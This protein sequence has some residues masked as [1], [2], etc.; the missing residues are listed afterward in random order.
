M[1]LKLTATLKL[2][3]K[4]LNTFR[5]LEKVSKKNVNLYIGPMGP[6]IYCVFYLKLI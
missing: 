4:D 1:K 2:I 6:K 3:L 5:L